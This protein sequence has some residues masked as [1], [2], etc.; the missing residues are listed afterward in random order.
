MEKRPAILDNWDEIQHDPVSM[1]PSDFTGM[2]KSEVVEAIVEWFFENFEDPAETT[3]YESAEGGYQYIWGGPYDAREIIESVF[4][5]TASKAAVEDAVNQIQRGGF[6]WVPNSN[7]LQ[8]PDEDD[9]E[10]EFTASEL[11]S[12]MLN[13]I[14]QFEDAISQIPPATPGIGHNNPPEEIDPL[15]E[16]VDLQDIMNS[17]AVLKAQPVEPEDGGKAATAAITRLK[18]WAVKLG[19]YVTKQADNFITEAVKEAGKQFGRWGTR[20]ALVVI[21]T[22]LLSLTDV[23]SQWLEAIGHNLPF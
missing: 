8:P 20:A 15:V 13:Q 17:V 4:E 3:P 2:K 23:A 6:D 21:G 5:D 22:R 10:H 14:S 18:E 19:G 1:P 12:E 16:Q 11:H 9:L 7:R